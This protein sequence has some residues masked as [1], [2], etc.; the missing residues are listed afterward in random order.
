MTVWRQSGL[1]WFGALIAAGMALLTQILLARHF[2]T[3]LFG[4]LSYA[5]AIAILISTFAFQ[6]IGEVAIRHRWPA[7]PTPLPSFC[8]RTLRSGHTRCFGLDPGRRKPRDETGPAGFVPSIRRR[9]DRPDRGD[10]C[11]SDRSQDH[12][13]RPLAGRIPKRA[14]H[15]GDWHRPS[16][17][18][19]DHRADRLDDRPGAVGHLRPSPTP[20]GR[21]LANP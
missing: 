14:P 18:G 10:D 16:G 9:P 20:T 21:R 12:R 4:A 2:D 3:A 15:G 11:V 19:G 1:V 5:Y 13:D 8:R 7:R 6:G 17:R